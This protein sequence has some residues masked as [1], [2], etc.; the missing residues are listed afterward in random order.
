[1]KKA[2]VK[3]PVEPDAVKSL[4]GEYAIIDAKFKPEKLA[5]GDIEHGKKAKKGA[6]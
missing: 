1:M 6:K 2:Y 5:D 3:H 4:R